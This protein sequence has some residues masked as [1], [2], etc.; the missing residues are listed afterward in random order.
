MNYE[1]LQAHMVDFKANWAQFGVTI[2]CDSWTGPTMMC[3]INFMVFCNGQ[4]FF[5]KS[6]NA[7]G[8][9]QNAEFIYDCIKKVIVEEIREQF[10]VHLV[11]DNG[12]NYKKACQQLTN[13]FSHITWQPCAAHTINLMLK[14]IR[15]FDEVAEVVDSAKREYAACYDERKDRW[16]AYSS[17]W[18]KQ[19]KFQAWMISSEWK[20]SDWE[21]DNE[22]LFATDCLMNRIWWDKMEL[23]L[24]SVTPIYSVLRFADQQ[25]NGTI[26][27]FL[28]RMIHAKE[29]IYGKLKH[30]DR[31]TLSLLGRFMEVISR[32]TKYLLNDTLMLAAATLDPEA[33]YK[34][35][36]A[37]HHSC[38]L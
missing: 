1:D 34:S 33:L 7:T 27:R 20:N 11:T 38:V 18:D 4:M 9:A 22:H 28:P 32:R 10:V 3:I 26:S 2:M 17:F 30:D 6:V 21:N 5:H 8:H 31:A 14:D 35:K 36:L 24:K 37:Q 25:K 19:D 15:H 29:E 16:R 13:E 23:L 12:S